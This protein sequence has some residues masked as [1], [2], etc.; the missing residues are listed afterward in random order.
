[1]TGGDIVN[2]SI[3]QAIGAGYLT[4]TSD[5]NRGYVVDNTG[6]IQAI[7]SA[8]VFFQGEMTV[9]NGII[10]TAGTG[11]VRSNGILTLENVTNNGSFHPTRNCNGIGLTLSGSLTNNGLI[12]D[13]QGECAALNIHLLGDVAINGL[14]NIVLYRSTTIDSTNKGVL[15]IGAE[16]SLGG[17]VTI[18]PS[19]INNGFISVGGLNIQNLNGPM[20][21]NNGTLL[22]GE[23]GTIQQAGNS[24]LTNYDARTHTLEGGT[25]IARNGTLNLNIGPVVINAADVSLIGSDSRFPAIDSIRENR[26]SFEVNGGRTFSTAS[27]SSSSEA[28]QA[29]DALY[30]YNVLTVGS[31]SSINVNGNYTQG[32]I[33]KLNIEIGS[34]NRAPGYLS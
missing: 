2:T 5:A 22:A 12:D 10:T 15:T 34:D 21:T 19:L 32:S 6:T 31:N 1:M 24:V 33:G 14:G 20:V 11:I 4:F 9:R 27:A 17:N 7:D 25:Y 18:S 23:G 13:L 8:T 29:S 26:G 3:I 28:L 30:N 16:Q